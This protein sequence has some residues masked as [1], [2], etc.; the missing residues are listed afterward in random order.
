MLESLDDYTKNLF[1]PEKLGFFFDFETLAGNLDSIIKESNSIIKESKKTKNNDYEYDSFSMPNKRS[2]FR[3]QFAFVHPKAHEDIVQA[4]K[5]VFKLPEC[6]FAKEADNQYCIHLQW[7][8]EKND[9]KNFTH[10]SI[11]SKKLDCAGSYKYYLHTDISKFYP[12]I[13]THAIDWVIWGKEEYKQNYGQY[14]KKAPAKLDTELQKANR[15]HTKGIGIGPLVF[16]YI[17]KLFTARFNTELQAFLTKE[18]IDCQFCHYVDD[19]YFFCNS[20]TDAEKILAKFE[21]ILKHYEL[22][23]NTDKVKLQKVEEMMWQPWWIAPMSDALNL[24]SSQSKKQNET[25]KKTSNHE[26]EKTRNHERAI[27]V[28]LKTNGK[29]TSEQALAYFMGGL[30][31]QLNET[32]GVTFSPLILSFITN[33][34]YREP[35]ILEKLF[36]NQNTKIDILEQLSHSATFKKTISKL[37]RDCLEKQRDL[38]LLC[39]LYVCKRFYPEELNTKALK[40]FLKTPATPLLFKCILAGTKDPQAHWLKTLSEKDSLRLE[41]FPAQKKPR[42]YGETGD[43]TSPYG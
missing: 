29:Y 25:A 24:F 36:L 28:V 26:K 10:D 43:D 6:D 22:Q 3:R 27:S 33:C 13:Y 2:L 35:S 19:Y 4:L 20:E 34:L 37:L 23:I 7:D 11:F 18:D 1:I 31:K 39:V 8:S 42:P 15:K 17:A 38:E 41:G 40:E 30:V 5:A 21:G 32:E 9:F 14:N 12:S 16:T